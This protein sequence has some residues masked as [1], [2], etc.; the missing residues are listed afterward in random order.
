MLPRRLAVDAGLLLGL[1]LATYVTSRG[2]I[3][4]AFDLG[5][6]GAVKFDR[7]AWHAELLGWWMAAALGMTAL[8]VRHRFPL[9]ALAGTMAMAYAHL[10]NPLISVTALDLAAPV[11]LYSVAAAELRRWI[12]YGSLAVGLV[13]AL[14]PRLLHQIPVYYGPW[15]GL[16]LIPAVAMLLAWLVGDRERTRHLYL[17]EATERA[18]DAERDRDHAAELAAA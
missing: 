3:A 17:H 10:V 11:V 12:S 2:A 9:V 4:A 5:A 7:G 15:R 1:A 13:V 16:S 6:A 8:L 18:E 14:L